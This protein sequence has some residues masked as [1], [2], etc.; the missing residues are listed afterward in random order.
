MHYKK[1]KIAIGGGLA[2][3][4]RLRGYVLVPSLVEQAA[5]VEDEA[6]GVLHKR[7]DIWKP[8]NTQRLGNLTA[9]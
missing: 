2:H 3:P 7:R 5:G 4:K 1:P 8:V 9:E 6:D